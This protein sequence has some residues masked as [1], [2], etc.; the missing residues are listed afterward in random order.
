MNWTPIAPSASPRPCR[1]TFR[2]SS[3]PSRVACRRVSTRPISPLSRFPRA[4][5]HQS[6]V[7]KCF[8]PTSNLFLFY[9]FRTLS[10][11]WTPASPLSSIAS[12]LFLSQWGCIPPPSQNLRT[13]MKPE[14]TSLASRRRLPRDQDVPRL[15]LWLRT[16]EVATSTQMSGNPTYQDLEAGPP[17]LRRTHRTF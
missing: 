5:D 3:L 11:Q 2:G 10:A 12:G 17:L 4:T 1:G 8:F 9:P 15:E 13:K 16:G 7:T 6:R 14:S